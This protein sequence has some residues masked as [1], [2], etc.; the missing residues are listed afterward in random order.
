MDAGNSL[1]LVSMVGAITCLYLGS[2]HMVP[3]SAERFRR[4]I[5]MGI[6]GAIVL[7]LLAQAVMIWNDSLA[8][9]W[10]LVII[11]VFHAGLMFWLRKPLAIFFGLLSLLAALLV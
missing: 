9:R 3:A 10:P 5:M 1:I 11:C 8:L 6:G 4:R 7:Y 2:R